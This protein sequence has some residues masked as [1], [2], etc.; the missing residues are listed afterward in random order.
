MAILKPSRRDM[1]KLSAAAPALALASPGLAA[2]SAPT[3]GQSNGYFKFTIGAAKL[4]VVSDGHFTTLAR[5]IGINADEPDVAAFMTAHFLDA[6]AHYEHTNHVVIELGDSKVL[7]DVGSGHRFAPTA[8]RMLDNLAAAGI[9]ESEITHVALTHAHPD[10]IWGIRDDFDEAIFPD[11]EYV[12]GGAEFDW[13]MTD[14]RVN[15]VEATDQSMVLGAVNS[16]T[17]ALQQMTMAMDGHQIA[18]GIRLI[19][20]PG[21]TVG[22]MSLIVE[23]DGDSILITGDAIRDPYVSLERPDWFSKI[24]MVPEQTVATR[25]RLL[26]MVTA[27]RM[28]IL[29]YHFPFPGVGHVVAESD[30]Y[31][32]IPALWQWS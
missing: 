9:S 26:D 28:A 20:S 18:P 7:V 29:S 13:W 3:S 17:A 32:F 21:H 1:L 16:L 5:D 19:A 22:H 11:A 30:A 27:D 12:I 24:D 10:H 8:G 25:R 23:S 15:M 6:S 4:T 14:D 31:R 2:I